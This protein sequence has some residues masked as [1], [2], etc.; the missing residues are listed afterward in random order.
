M[1]L[2]KNPGLYLEV[3]LR[4]QK[5][6]SVQHLCFLTVFCE[7]VLRVKTVTTEEGDRR[8]TDM[9]T[10]PDASEERGV[11]RQQVRFSAGLLARSQNRQN[12]V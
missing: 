12:P 4:R 7:K 10:P 6:I 2:F 9:T 3:L 1:Q 11:Q 5:E 8:E